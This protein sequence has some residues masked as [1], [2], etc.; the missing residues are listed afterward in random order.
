MS[1]HARLRTGTRTPTVGLARMEGED[2]GLGQR[3]LFAEFLVLEGEL[4]DG[5]DQGWDVLAEL[6]EFLVLVRDGLFE[7]GDLGS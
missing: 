2:G 7:L 1:A 3:E 6:G 4:V 5:S